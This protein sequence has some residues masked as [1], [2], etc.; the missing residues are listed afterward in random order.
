M[1]KRS[2]KDQSK[3]VTAGAQPNQ[4]PAGNAPLSY[5]SKQL[6]PLP[7]QSLGWQAMGYGTPTGYGNESATGNYSPVSVPGGNQQAWGPGF[8]KPVG[9]FNM[10][11]TSG[12]YQ[13]SL[14]NGQISPAQI[15][16]MLPILQRLQS[17]NYQYGSNPR[18][19]LPAMYQGL[20]FTGGR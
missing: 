20:P 15:A 17:Q 7:P 11:D 1:F 2:N 19:N 5:G 8:T 12:S 18:G 16:A 14:Q 3:A 4:T 6:S 13:P 9:G 10:N